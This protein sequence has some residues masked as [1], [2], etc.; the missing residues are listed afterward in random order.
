MKK[1]LALVLALVLTLS[2]VA[3]AGEKPAVVAG[4]GIVTEEQY[5][6]GV[7]FVKD[8]SATYTEIAA[9]FGEGGAK[10][11]DENWSDDY[12]YY[13][14]TD[15]TRTIIVTFSVNKGVENSFT[16]TGDINV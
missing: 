9:A 1:L 2:L 15:G 13:S 5:V 7:K 14:W 4:D 12:H 8:N 11:L 10:T 16:F 3:C 6:A